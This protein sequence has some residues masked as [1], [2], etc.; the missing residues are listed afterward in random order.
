MTSASRRHGFSLIELLVV[1]A[2]IGVLLGLV[3]PALARTRAAARRTVCLNNLRMLHLACEQYKNDNNDLYPY[4]T[5][6]IAVEPGWIRPLDQLQGYLSVPLPTYDEAEDAAITGQ[7]FLCPSDSSQT[8]ING[9]SY[10]Y[11]PSE[12]MEFQGQEVVS[13]WLRET[14]T[15]PLWY[16]SAGSHSFGPPSPPGYDHRGKNAVLA[17]GRIGWLTELF[18]Y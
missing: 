8:A 4:A 13:K 12:V 6:Y 16:E 9:C 18:E 14:P 11:L 2:V 17:N 15:L 1:I 3:A 10:V 7:P 5:R